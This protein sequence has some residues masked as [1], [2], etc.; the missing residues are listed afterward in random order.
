MQWAQRSR[1][2]PLCFR[3]LALKDEEL[4]QLLPFGE[5]V[6]LEQAQAESSMLAT[7]ELERILVRLAAADRR[8]ERQQRHRRG[9]HGDHM[10]VSQSRNIP[11]QTLKTNSEEERC[12]SSWPP[13][14]PS[15]R[16]SSSPTDEQEEG[17]S[18]LFKSAS[19][20]LKSVKSK[21]AGW[22]L[23]ESLSKTT[24]EIKSLFGAPSSSQDKI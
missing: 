17:V 4:N 8:E 9:R 20:S 13:A 24:Q 15:S 6:P 12:A 22:R 3:A 21:F 5:Y 10:P 23:K 14:G 16:S 19:Q 7:W 11:S 2:C 18:P 1:E